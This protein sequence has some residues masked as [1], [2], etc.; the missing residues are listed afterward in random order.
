[1]SVAQA[2]SALALILC[3]GATNAARIGSTLRGGPTLPGEIT[4]WM[5]WARSMQ[6]N[7]TRR[8]GALASSSL[9]NSASYGADFSNWQTHDGWG[10]YRGKVEASEEGLR[11]HSTSWDPDK[12]GRIR[13][14]NFLL[15]TDDRPHTYIYVRFRGAANSGKN[16]YVTLRESRC[17]D[18]GDNDCDEVDLVESY[19]KDERAEGFY[20]K[21]GQRQVDGPCHLSSD[22]GNY[23]HEYHMWLFK[24]E[25]LIICEGSGEQ[26]CPGN[27]FNGIPDQPMNLYV[28][29][30]D[31][32]SISGSESWC[33][34]R[35][36]GDT[37]CALQY[38]YI[39]SDGGPARQSATVV[40]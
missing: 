19:G 23:M 10:G 6:R 2:L 35:T 39:L 26:N 32:T 30:W 22:S 28:G 29:E 36:D 9:P 17:A 7:S 15:N 8:S 14:E 37:W 12:E 31:C 38:I 13:F 27:W 11:I 4:A 3:T 21:R 25:H 40:S 33:G 16:S 24:G 20:Y 18:G 34:S 1:M 5:E